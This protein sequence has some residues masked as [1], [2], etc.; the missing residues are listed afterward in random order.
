MARLGSSSSRSRI[1]QHGFTL[2]ELLVSLAVGGALVSGGAG[3]HAAVQD[4]R[5]T[6]VANEL[7]THLN[8]ARSEAIKRH[9]RVSVCPTQDQSTCLAADGR[10]TFWQYGWLI[11]ADENHNGE[12]EPAEII[13]VQPPA[14]ARLVIRTSH[15]RPEI[16]YQTTGTAGGSTATF[17]V[18][19]ANGAQGARYVTVSNTGRPKISR[20]T[21]S[22]VRCS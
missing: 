12:P 19:G 16:T 8:L 13:R 7:V 17:A 10:Y 11:Y 4:S 14:D 3:L 5:Q 6:T 21:T 9:T 1:R 2:Q 20:T 15:G 18:C 22:D